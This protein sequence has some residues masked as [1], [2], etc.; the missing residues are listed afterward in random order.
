MVSEP[1]S[2]IQ[3]SLT[4]HF[5]LRV[6]P[7]S[8]E[9][10]ASTHQNSLIRSTH[11]KRQENGVRPSPTHLVSTCRCDFCAPRSNCSSSSG[12][13]MQARIVRDGLRQSANWRILSPSRIPPRSTSCRRMTRY[14]YASSPTAS[15]MLESR[16]G[17]EAL[18]RKL[19][20]RGK[21]G[22]G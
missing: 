18:H 11:Q 19:A 4:M 5:S 7:P 16:P 20:L 13:R 3:S 21:P 6:I 14:F 9:R 12:S 15:T 8:L 22:G 2:W 1:T 17:G 10:E